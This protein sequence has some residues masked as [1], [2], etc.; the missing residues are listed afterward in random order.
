MPLRFGSAGVLLFALV[1]ALPAAD[2]PPTPQQLDAVWQDFIQHGD[3][4][5]QRARAGMRVLIAAPKL[6]VPYLQARLK[7]A[8][9]TDGRKIDQAIADLDSASFPTREKAAADLET[10]GLAAATAMERK[11]AQN[12]SLEVRQRLETLLQ[13][14]AYRAMTP[15]DLRNIRAVEVL[16][17]I[18]TPEARALLESLA[19]GGEGALITEQARTALTRLQRRTP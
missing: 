19:K 8:P 4:G 3:D 2:A 5:A 15:D 13:M 16:A 12:P 10:L 1:A 7:P 9:A 17:A 14:T 6:A 11:L 18:G